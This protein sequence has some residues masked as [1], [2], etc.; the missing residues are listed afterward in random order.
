MRWTSRSALLSV[1]AMMIASA[2]VAQ[3][4]RNGNGSGIKVSKD[5]YVPPPVAAAGSKTTVYVRGTTTMM[6]EPWN[7][8]FTLFDINAYNAMSE[9]NIAWHIATADTLRAQLASIAQ[10]KLTDARAREFITLAASEEVSG[11]WSDYWRN[12]TGKKSRS[13][14]AGHLEKINE[15]VTDEDVGSAPLSPDP[16]IE[17]LHQAIQKFTLMPTGAIFDAA[18]YRFMVAHYGNEYDL[19]SR[20]RPNAHDDDFEAFIDQ[21]FPLYATRRDQALSILVSLPPS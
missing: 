13:A 1:G 12:A 14:P 19:L 6:D 4:S 3:N 9:P 2:A 15:I 21:S 16:E 7:I 20:G 8:R 17:R 11:A 5:R 18:F 10:A